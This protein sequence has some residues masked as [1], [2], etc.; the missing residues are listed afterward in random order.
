MPSMWID[1]PLKLTNGEMAVC[2][3]HSNID[4]ELNESAFE[5]RGGSIE[6]LI[7]MNPI[8]EGNLKSGAVTYKLIVKPISN[9]LSVGIKGGAVII[10]DIP[11]E[12]CKPISIE[13]EDL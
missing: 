7:R 8:Q 1:A 11:N 12:P 3:V 5:V 10:E 6:E 13:I 2:K 9:Q 4:V